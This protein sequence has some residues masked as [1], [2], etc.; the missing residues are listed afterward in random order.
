MAGRT[1]EILLGPPPHSEEKRCDWPIVVWW[2]MAELAL[3]PRLPNSHSSTLPPVP[4]MMP[5]TDTVCQ[6]VPPIMQ[7]PRAMGCVGHLKGFASIQGFGVG[8]FCYFYGRR[9][10]GRKESE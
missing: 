9:E 10:R 1:L 2:G 5:L 3:E 4:A 8:D 7:S 6:P